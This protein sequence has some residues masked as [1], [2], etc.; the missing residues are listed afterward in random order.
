MVATLTLPHISRRYHL[1]QL[2]GAGGMGSVYAARDRLSGEMVALKR[3]ATAPKNLA[4]NPRNMETLGATDQFRYALAHEF[5]VMASLVHPNVI[6]VL[7]YGFDMERQPFYTMEL[8][9]HPQTIVEAGY[10]LTPEAKS[11]LILQL[12]QALVYLHRRQIIHRD[13][14]PANILCAD[15]VVKLVDFGLSEASH[16]AQITGGTVPYMAPELLRNEP[17]TVQSDLYAVGVIAYEMLAGEYPFSATHIDDLL[18]KIQ[19][20]SPDLSRLDA[21]R[22]IRKMIGRLLEKDPAD[23]YPSAA[24]AVGACCAAWDW[25]QPEPPAIREGFLQA[26][27]FVGREREIMTLAAALDAVQNGRGGAWLIAGESGVGKTRFV[28]ELRTLAMVR[29]IDVLRG[30]AANSG[31]ML[32][33]L[34]RD[35]IRWLSVLATPTPKEAATLATVIPDLPAILEQ[36]IPP[37][38][39]GDSERLPEVVEALLCRLP[40]PALIVLDDLQWAGQES[41]TLLDKLLPLTEKHPI[42]IVGTFRDD[43]RPNLPAEFPTMEFFKLERFEPAQIQT[44]SESILGERGADPALARYLEDQSEGNIFFLIEV[45]RALSETTGRLDQVSVPSKA[46][47]VITGGIREMLG[48]RLDRLPAENRTLLEFAAVAGRTLDLELL[49]ALAG[50][51]ELTQWLSDCIENAI[52][53]IQDARW[54]FT[55]DRLRDAV[56]ESIPPE[57]SQAMYR[58]VAGTVE[59]LYPD[60]PDHYPALAYYWLCADD[61][62]KAIAYYNR[63]GTHAAAL[64]IDSRARE[65]YDKAVYLLRGLPTSDDNR[66]VLADTLIKRVRA[67]LITDSPRVNL[68]R[69]D[70]ASRLIVSLPHHLTLSRDELHQRMMMHYALGRSHYHYMQP[71]RALRDFEKM[72]EYAEQL[73]G[74]DLLAAP[75]SLTGRVYQLQGYFGKAL[76]PLQEAFPALKRTE[77]WTDWLINLAYVGFCLTARGNYETGQAEGARALT[78]AQELRHGSAIAVC[79]TLLGMQHWQAGN[80]AAGIA[81][82]DAGIASASATGDWLI[83]H[84]ARG[85]RAWNLAL[86]SDLSGA[87]SEWDYY[88]EML[89]EFGG[90]LILRDWFMAGQAE[91]TFLKGDYLDAITQADDAINFAREIDGIFAEGVAHRVA[92]QAFFAQE[93]PDYATIYQHLDEGLNCLTAGEAVME[94]IRIHKLWARVALRRGDSSRSAYHIQKAAELE[95]R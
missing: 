61:P 79:H 87:A 56:L 33:H 54:Q 44:L 37:G 55:H 84:L 14:K 1:L 58:Q 8:L 66:A 64:Y 48:R 27:R 77:N 68:E 42:L 30:G 51:L 41:L 31:G 83:L 29:G 81:A 45:I 23:R 47:A 12:L 94:A 71:N 22:L 25:E 95:S 90:R 34:W 24:D 65:L 89:R 32:Y 50:G 49:N 85:M 10:G 40:H 35:P 19:F 6:R 2:L 18:E 57:R 73:G 17:A 36:P 15:G 75:R 7:D 93:W 74:G 76:G 4:I 53:E 67:A 20:Q 62:E 39:A 80:Y 52:I 5:Q 28:S 78:R 60:S 91:T 92:A 38:V 70:E 46:A 82:C 11:E 72:H 26:A 88:A 59:A 43:E 16:L 13:L 9:P 69:L 63:A 3:V 21:P 86:S